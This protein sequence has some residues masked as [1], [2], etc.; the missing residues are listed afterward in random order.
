[1]N[2]KT[3]E[4]LD[5]TTPFFTCRPSSRAVG[6]RTCA[7]TCLSRGRNGFG[8]G[9]GESKDDN[10]GESDNDR[11]RE[12]GR[13]GGRERGKKGTSERKVGR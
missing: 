3:T 5:W 12:R 4:S 8:G 1:M 11:Q 13:G 9:R 2:P 7:S 6:H 10:G